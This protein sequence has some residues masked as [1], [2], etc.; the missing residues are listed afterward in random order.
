[1]QLYYIS[2]LHPT[3]KHIYEQK[4]RTY[5]ENIVIIEISNYLVQH[6]L[7]KLVHE[8]KYMLLHSEKKYMQN[9]SYWSFNI[10]KFRKIHRR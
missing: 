3:F 8:E 5:I 7:E 4:V 1:M 6:G 2:S 9:L 10:H